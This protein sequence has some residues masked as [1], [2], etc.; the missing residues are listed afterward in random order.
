M[1]WSGWQR[2]SAGSWSRGHL[3][4]RVRHRARHGVLRLR[5]AL[6]CRLQAQ[7]GAGGRKDLYELTTVKRHSHE[8]DTLHR[9]YCYGLGDT[10]IPGFM[11][12]LL[13]NTYMLSLQAFADG[14]KQR[15]LCAIIMPK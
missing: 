11:S 6:R 3:P 10:A 14:A 4:D 12:E 15:K 1:A 8:I 7:H 2:H 9:D 13:W 5:S